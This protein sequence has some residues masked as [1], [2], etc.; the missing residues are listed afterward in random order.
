MSD[1]GNVITHHMDTVDAGSLK[2][3]AKRARAISLLGE[4]LVLAIE[5]GG[6]IEDAPYAIICTF[7][8]SAPL[9]KNRAARGVKR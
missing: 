6:P 1:F 4:P 9:P 2:D 8:K 3:P 5:A 7:G